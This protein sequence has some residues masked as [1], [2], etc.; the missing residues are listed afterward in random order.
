[1]TPEAGGADRQPYHDE[2]L[3]RLLQ[4]CFGD[5][6]DAALAV[7]WPRLRWVELAGGETL[8]RQGEAGDAMYLLVSGRLRAYLSSEADGTHLVGEI[9]RGELVGEIDSTI[10]KLVKCNSAQGYTDVTNG[11]SARAGRQRSGSSGRCGTDRYHRS[12]VLGALLF[13][14]LQCLKYKLGSFSCQQLKCNSFACLRLLAVCVLCCPCMYYAAIGML[15]QPLLHLVT[16]V[17]ICKY[18]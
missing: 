15:R 10:A 6:G 1:L 12:S 5:V 18:L 7:L 13:P 9:T 4:G 3:Y 16:S 2:L 17:E 11:A 8:M 14:L